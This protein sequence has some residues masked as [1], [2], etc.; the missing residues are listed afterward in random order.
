MIL[1]QGD[2]ERR[3]GGKDEFRVSLPPV[4]AVIWSTKNEDSEQRRL[5]DAGDV[6][7]CR[8]CRLIDHGGEQERN[9]VPQCV[10]TGIYM[11]YFAYCPAHHNKSDVKSVLSLLPISSP[12]KGIRNIPNRG[13]L[14]ACQ[15]STVQHH[16][17]RRRPLLLSFSPSV[18]TAGG[19]RSVIAVYLP[20]FIQKSLTVFCLHPV[21]NRAEH[22]SSA[23]ISSRL[24]ASVL[25]D[26]RAFVGDVLFPAISRDNT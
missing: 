11:F 21:P 20:I 9:V 3:V 19:D 2:R 23:Q 12:I 17:R 1:V 6:H 7:R 14:L 18:R 22:C 15:P 25:L 16:R 13:R 8:D 24:S 4:P 5:L 10:L 26:D